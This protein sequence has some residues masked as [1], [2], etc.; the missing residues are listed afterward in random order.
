MQQ[1]PNGQHCRPPKVN[2]LLT[3]LLLKAS[4]VLS[5]GILAGPPRGNC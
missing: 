2:Q 1:T 3:V 5:S 4:K